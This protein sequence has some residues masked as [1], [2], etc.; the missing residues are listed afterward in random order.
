MKRRVLISLFIFLLLVNSLC[1]AAQNDDIGTA[2]DDERTEYHN[3]PVTFRAPNACL[4]WYGALNGND[5]P[6]RV[7]GELIVSLCG[8]T[9]FVIDKVCPKCLDEGLGERQERRRALSFP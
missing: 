1:A 3:G 8:S 7:I 9:Y 5:Q 4:V 6:E 2:R